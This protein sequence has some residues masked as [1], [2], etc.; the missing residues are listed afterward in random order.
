MREAFRASLF[1]CLADPGERDDAAASEFFEDGLL[2]VEDGRVVEAG[3]ASALLESLSADTHVEDLS[4]KLIVP[5][6]IDCHVHYQIGR[7]HV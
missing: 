3:P 1:H 4:G 2:I 6:L 7:A 5:G